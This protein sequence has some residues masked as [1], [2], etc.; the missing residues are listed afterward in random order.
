D[1]CRKLRE[2]GIF[3]PI[4]MLTAKDDELDKVLG[5]ELGADDYIIKPFSPREVISRI[6][7][8]LRRTTI[9]QMQSFEKY[10]V[11]ALEIFP[12]KY[13]VKKNDLSISLTSKEFE[14]LAYLAENKGLAL[15]REQILD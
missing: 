12:Q 10:R 11:G 14:L 9:Q 15:S 1:V 5:L 3:I 2:Q 6:K 13:E 4:I 8:V 7:A